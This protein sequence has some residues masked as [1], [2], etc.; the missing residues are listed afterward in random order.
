MNKQISEKIIF[1]LEK[2]LN[3]LR[4]P[5]LKAIITGVIIIF[6]SAY[7][8]TNFQEVS[9][10]LVGIN[11]NIIQLIIALALVIFS[12]LIG[13]IT[14]WMILSWLGYQK[15]FLKIIRSY[16]FSNLAKYIPGFVW[17][18]ASRTIFLQNVNIPLNIIAGAIVIEFILVTS[19]GGIFSCVSFFAYGNQIVQFNIYQNLIVLLI[20]IILI[21]I[22]LFI[23]KIIDLIFNNDEIQLT[24]R[25]YIL[26]ICIN[27]SGWFIMSLAYLL[28]SSSLGISNINLIFAVFLHSTNFFIGNLFLPIPNGLL[29]REAIIIF[30][31]KNLIN[32]NLLILTSILFRIMIFSSEVILTLYLYLHSKLLRIK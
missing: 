5:I 10:L 32:Q 8:I 26:A 18:Y 30:I 1:Y 11:I 19:I 17:Q 29:I 23:P 14:W 2:F 12:V 15:N 20:F 7:F 6:A 13:T 31:A 4:N 21:L 22:I 25:Y 24:K 16:T 9:S 27:M 3:F 28:I